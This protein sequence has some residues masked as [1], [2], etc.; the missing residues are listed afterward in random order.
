MT[1]PTPELRIGRKERDA[2]LNTLTQAYVDE[3]IPTLE[4]YD[5]RVEK[6]LSAT[7]QTQLDTLTVD[8]TP[9]VVKKDAQLDTLA[10]DNSD[11]DSY[12]GGR[13]DGGEEVYWTRAR[14]MS[15]FTLFFLWCGVGLFWF[16]HVFNVEPSTET[17]TATVTSS[18]PTSCAENTCNYPMILTTNA[19]EKVEVEGE[20][21]KSRSGWP[22]LVPVGEEET[23][24]KIN[25]EW[26]N[27]KPSQSER[28]GIST[29][30]TIGITLMSLLLYKSLQLKKRGGTDE[31]IHRRRNT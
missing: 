1:P 31:T 10:R 15:A 9:A 22:I 11:S 6:A 7:T 30:A 13:V 29:F 4:E 28:I 17:Q 26:K 25:G 16:F 23:F 27:G 19:G 24:Q 21:H 12:G 18:T 5:E 2:T 3:R 20:F 14:T 8:L